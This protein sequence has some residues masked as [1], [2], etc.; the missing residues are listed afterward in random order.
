MNNTKTC[1]VC[2]K[3]YTRVPYTHDSNWERRKYCESYDC[4]RINS[5]INTLK[6]FGYKIQKI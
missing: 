2:G 6:K 1:I 3:K 4:V 5:Y